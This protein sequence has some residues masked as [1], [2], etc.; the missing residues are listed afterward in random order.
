MSKYEPIR[1]HLSGAAREAFRMTFL[2]IENVLGF[3]LPPSARRHRPWWDNGPTNNT[4]TR[5]WLAA[6]Y[7][8]AQVDIGRE[9]L[10]FRK[11][12]QTLR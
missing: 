4:M 11:R 12:Q 5:Q 2:E 9:T 3:R 7:E 10:V 8:T 1:H 6:G